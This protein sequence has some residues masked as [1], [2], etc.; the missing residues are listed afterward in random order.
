MAI[1]EKNLSKLLNEMARK[2]QE[3]LKQARRT[4]IF[5][6][7]VQRTNTTRL[8]KIVQKYG[9]PTIHLVGK[10]ASRNA[11]LIIQHTNHDV[12][13]QKKC[14]KLMKE[15]YVRNPQDIALENIA[16]LTDRILVNTKKKQLFGT[17]FYVNKVNKNGVL[18]YWPI[19]DFKNL[20]KRRKEYGIPPF[21]KYLGAIKSVKPLRIR[22]GK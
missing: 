18:M 6:D 20:D 7:K 8:K 11:W 17:Q 16:F 1:Q 4:L 10:R 19:R 3:K 15:I 21:R 2:D 5:N 14:L 12:R 22:T 13:F 9:W